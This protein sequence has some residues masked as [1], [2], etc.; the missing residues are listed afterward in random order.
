MDHQSWRGW[1]RYSSINAPKKD[2]VRTFPLHQIYL[3]DGVF[4]QTR[5]G[6]NWEG[7]ILT[8]STCKHYM[9]TAKKDWEGLWLAGFTPKV[10]CDENYLL[11]LARIEHVFDSNYDLG[12]W[13]WRHF[14]ATWKEKNALRNPF[15]DIYPPKRTD[16]SDRAKYNP[17][18]FHVPD[19][20]CRMEMDKKWGVP[21]W[22]KDIDYEAKGVR[23]KCFVFTSVKLFKKPT[24]IATRPLH[25]SGYKGTIADLQRGVK[26]V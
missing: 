19:G 3:E 12:Q 20:H 24:W 5:S 21:K 22:T 14:P 15:G 13:M 23:P 25:R 1:G 9:R 10:G 18:N 26:R 6:P 4:K 7:G 8:L 2:E 17:R 16:L 11:F